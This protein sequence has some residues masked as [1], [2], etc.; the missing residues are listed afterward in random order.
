VERIGGI[1]LSLQV[2]VGACGVENPTRSRGLDL[3]V[4]MGVGLWGYLDTR[5]GVIGTPGPTRCELRGYDCEWARDAF[6][7]SNSAR[8]TVW[9]RPS[10]SPSARRC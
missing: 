1:S 5:S 6:S 7:V 8:E 4:P 10:V 2:G 3:T 9:S